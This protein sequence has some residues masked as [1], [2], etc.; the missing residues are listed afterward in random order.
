[1]RKMIASLS[2]SAL[3]FAGLAGSAAA[4]TQDGLV[5]VNVG[6]ITIQDINVTVAANVLAGVCAN[7]D[8][9]VVLAVLSNVDATGGPSTL[10]CDLRGPRG[11]QTITITD[12]G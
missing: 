8:A 4:V 2:A 5:N 3:L 11:D 7:V 1:M 12:N 9:D 6:D 10:T